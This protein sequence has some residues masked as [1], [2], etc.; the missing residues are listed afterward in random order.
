MENEGVGGLESEGIRELI[1][2][3][4][5]ERRHEGR[6]RSTLCQDRSVLHLFASFLEK[7]RVCEPR[8]INRRHLEA[9]QDHLREVY[10]IPHGRRK[11]QALR[12]TTVYG[13]LARS[14]AFVGF[15][16]KTDRL[17]V[18]PRGGFLLP[19]YNRSRRLF[20]PTVD[21]VRA[22]LE[23]IPPCGQ[24]ALRDRALFEL[25]YSTGLRAGEASHLDVYDLDLVVG[26]VCVREG[27]G[28]RD[29]TVPVG[30]V[31]AEFLTRYLATARPLNWTPAAGNALFVTKR[32]RRMMGYSVSVQ[33][34]CWRD[35]VRLPQ[36]TPHSFRHAVATHMLAGGA[37]VRQVQELLGHRE[38]TTT[39]LY[40]HLVISDLIRVHRKSHPRG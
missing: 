26:T 17:L 12:S 28:G 11:G 5:Q 1:P 2:L 18:D 10:R 33:C 34:A 36:M 4:L 16:V 40:M 39:N 9:W 27:K 35:G 32:G 3:Y 13:W 24:L 31:A 29:R 23:S 6:S 22:F 15:L 8:A 37:D 7:Q 14:R 20:I 19:R 25:L 38:I 30:S 21:E